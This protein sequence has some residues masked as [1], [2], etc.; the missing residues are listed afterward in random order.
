MANRTKFRLREQKRWFRDS[1]FILQF[2]SQ[3]ELGEYQN[4]IGLDNIPPPD[5][6]PKMIITNWHD[7]EFSTTLDYDFCNLIKS[8]KDYRFVLRKRMFKN[9]VFVLQYYRYYRSISSDM[10]SNKWRDATSEEALQ[11]MI[12]NKL[13]PLQHQ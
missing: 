12:D 8:I 3:R 9:S 2:Q 11:F 13:N 6:D 4:P 10:G 7:A 5:W 1:I